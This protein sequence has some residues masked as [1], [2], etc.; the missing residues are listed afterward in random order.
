VTPHDC[1]WSDYAGYAFETEVLK[2]ATA[3]NA[4][5]GEDGVDLATGGWTYTKYDGKFLEDHNEV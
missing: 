2:L 4:T 5:L 3:L 1:W